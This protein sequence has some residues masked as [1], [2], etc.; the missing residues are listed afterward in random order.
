MTERPLMSADEGIRSRPVAH[1]GFSDERACSRHSGVVRESERV[2][3]EG[4]LSIIEGGVE[5]EEEAGV[6]GAVVKLLELTEAKW[7]LRL[8]AKELRLEATEDQLSVHSVAE[9]ASLSVRQMADGCGFLSS[10]R[11]K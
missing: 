6:R 9:V 11:W 8:S 4:E 3:T 10:R 1:L 2:G 7:L 5:S